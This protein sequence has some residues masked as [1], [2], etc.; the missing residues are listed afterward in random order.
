MLLSPHTWIVPK[1]PEKFARATVS[2][3]CSNM[4]YYESPLS[5]GEAKEL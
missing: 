5:E 4:N 3:V 1:L 2:A